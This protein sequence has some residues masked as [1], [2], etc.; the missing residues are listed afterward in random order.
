[1]ALV[2]SRLDRAPDGSLMTAE[3]VMRM[4]IESDKETRG[5]KIEQFKLKSSLYSGN[6]FS[7]LPIDPEQESKDAEKTKKENKPK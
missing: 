1:M 6:V 7:R 5:Q 3:K 4:C 2:L